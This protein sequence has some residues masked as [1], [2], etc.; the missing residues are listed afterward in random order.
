MTEDVM[1]LNLI[2][3][4]KKALKKPNKLEAFDVVD[5]EL[6]NLQMLDRVQRLQERATID[7]EDG[8]F[9][10]YTKDPKACASDEDENSG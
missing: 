3:R 1:G 6:S 8:W 7:K 5:L 4:F 10:C 2:H 9:L